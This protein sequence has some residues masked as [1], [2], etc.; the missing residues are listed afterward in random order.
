MSYAR[1]YASI[2][3]IAM[4]LFLAPKL[5]ANDPTILRMTDMK[6]S[7]EVALIWFDAL[8]SKAMPGLSRRVGGLPQGIETTLAVTTPMFGVNYLVTTR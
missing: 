8:V 3:K 7:A 6:K 1:L 5:D 4:L 2:T